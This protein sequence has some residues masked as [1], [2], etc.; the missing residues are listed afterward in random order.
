MPL[1]VTHCKNK[2][3]LPLSSF[4]FGPQNRLFCLFQQMG[5]EFCALPSTLLTPFQGRGKTYLIGETGRKN[6]ASE[7]QP[8]VVSLCLCGSAYSQAGHILSFWVGKNSSGPRPVFRGKYGMQISLLCY[9]GSAGVKVDFLAG[10]PALQ[11]QTSL[12]WFAYIK[13]QFGVKFNF[14]HSLIQLSSNPGRKQIH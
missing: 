5:R 7:A 2:I 12:Q 9:W 4:T 10:G 6:G 3:L 11:I 14:D 13:I 1:K 8:A